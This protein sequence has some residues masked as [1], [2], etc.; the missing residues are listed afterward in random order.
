MNFP[1]LD[2]RYQT[3]D[4]VQIVTVLDKWKEIFDILLKVFDISKKVSIRA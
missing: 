1:N 3:D 4:F 2:L